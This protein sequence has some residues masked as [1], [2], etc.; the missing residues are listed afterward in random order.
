M[1]LLVRDAASGVQ[2]VQIDGQGTAFRPH[3]PARHPRELALPRDRQSLFLGRPEV[4]VFPHRGAAAVGGAHQPLGDDQ[5]Q[6]FQQAGHAT[7][8]LLRRERLDQPAE[9]FRHAV[10]VGGGVDQVPGLRRQDH[11]VDGLRVARLADQ[12]HSRL[13]PQAVAHPGGE[14]LEV[15]ADL[16]LGDQRVG[17]RHEIVDELDGGLVGDDLAVRVGLFQQMADDRAQQ[18]GFAGAGR[19]GHDHQSLL[20]HQMPAQVLRQIE[21]V[22]G[23]RGGR[24]GPQGDLQTPL[25]GGAGGDHVHPVAGQVVPAAPDLVGAVDVLA[26]RQLARRVVAVNRLRAAVRLGG[27]PAAA[28]DRREPAEALGEHEVAGLDRDVRHPVVGR[29]QQQP[30]EPR[31]VEGRR[32]RQAR[33][34]KTRQLRIAGNGRFSQI[35]QRSHG[36]RSQAVGATGVVAAGAGAAPSTR[37]STFGP[38]FGG[39]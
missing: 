13:A 18:G 39:R 9:G 37:T 14:A 35:D 1:A 21:A 16:V 32:L 4:Q 11:R 26:P 5:A 6:R 19:P 8:A 3:Q 34:R 20:E 22:Q 25:A 28:G 7:L 15:I 30:V 33:V 24:D 38:R 17:A 2:R 23:R 29:P 27:R 10:G 31:P 36:G 12:D